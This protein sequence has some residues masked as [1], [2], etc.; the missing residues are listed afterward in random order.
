M[1]R[2][3]SCSNRCELMV[4]G[5]MWSKARNSLSIWMAHVW[6]DSILCGEHC[7]IRFVSAPGGLHHLL[8]RCELSVSPAH[9]KT[10]SQNVCLAPTGPWFS[11]PHRRCCER[12]HLSFPDRAVPFDELD[13]HL[14]DESMSPCAGYHR[15]GAPSLSGGGDSSRRAFADWTRT[16]KF[17]FARF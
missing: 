11:A 12:F 2:E 5:E 4:I 16:G 1:L 15:S 10:I 13:I 17:K 9:A 8:T 6:N 3:I 14:Q 7:V